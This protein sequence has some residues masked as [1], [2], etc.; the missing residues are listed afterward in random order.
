MRKMT[1]A[2]RLLFRFNGSGAAGFSCHSFI[3]TQRCNKSLEFE[4][5]FCKC[6]HSMRPLSC[7]IYL[8]TSMFAVALSACNSEQS[9]LAPQPTTVHILPIESAALQSRHP[10][11]SFKDIAELY[12][13]GYEKRKHR[14]RHKPTASIGILEEVPQVHD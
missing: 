10:G 2:G 5:S 12:R 11:E 4:Q 7:S 3:L 13:H 6:T 8:F 1:D 9:A 14:H